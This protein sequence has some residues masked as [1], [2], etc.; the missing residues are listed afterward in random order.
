[1]TRIMVCKVSTGEVF[2]KIL[3][4][5]FQAGLGTGV[6]LFWEVLVQFTAMGRENPIENGQTGVRESFLGTTPA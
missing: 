1:M 5:V 2:V 6:R 3:E 4:K